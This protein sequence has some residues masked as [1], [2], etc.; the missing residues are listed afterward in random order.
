MQV[1]FA[2]DNKVVYEDG[3]DSSDVGIDCEGSYYVEGD[4]IYLDL[5]VIPDEELEILAQ[6]ITG[7]IKYSVQGNKLILNWVEGER[8]KNL[9]LFPFADDFKSTLTK[10]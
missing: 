10:E 4:K 3:I 5:E 7:T 9:F 1:E 8:L 2:P 6:K